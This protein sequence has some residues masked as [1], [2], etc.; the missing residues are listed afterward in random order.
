[1]REHAG[2]GGV[3]RWAPMRRGGGD[4][5]RKKREGGEL[6]G[7][8]GL[9]QSGWWLRELLP[10]PVLRAPE[11]Q[12]ACGCA[13]HG[14]VCC[15]VLHA[16]TRPAA[17][18]TRARWLGTPA[19]GGGS[20]CGGLRHEL[21]LILPRGAPAG[22]RREAAVTLEAARFFNGALPVD[23]SKSRPRVRL[24][25]TNLLLGVEDRENLP[26]E[27]YRRAGE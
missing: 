23:Q 17:R 22:P 18:H 24:H 6:C 4:G 19:P 9:Q 20:S 14:R 21:M 27:K 3:L 13:T 10:G 26:K 11:R 8:R 15:A 7:G 16:L 25:M 12:L 2:A 1:M 5:V